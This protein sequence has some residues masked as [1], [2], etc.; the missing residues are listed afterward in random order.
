MKQIW[1]NSDEEF[2]D[3]FIKYTERIINAKITE[4]ELQNI[5]IATTTPLAKDKPTT[6]ENVRYEKDIR[7]IMIATIFL[8]LIVNVAVVTNMEEILQ[9]KMK[10]Q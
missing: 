8:R 6:L 3:V 5:A 4:F 10:D 7:P 2:K 1:K 9:H